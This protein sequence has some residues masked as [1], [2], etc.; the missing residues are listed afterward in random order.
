MARKTLKSAAAILAAASMSLAAVACSS[1]DANKAGDAATGAAATSTVD[2]TVVTTAAAAG[3]GQG[4]GEEVE[5]PT[6]DGK[7]EKVPAPIA[8][9]WKE[10]GAAEGWMGGLT[11]VQKKDGATLANFQHGSIASSEETGAHILRGKIRELWLQDGALDSKVGLPVENE[12]EL[13]GAG[14]DQN[15]K[16]GMIKWAPDTAGQWAPNIDAK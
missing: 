8:A 10:N 4:Q 14:W 12:K 7:T 16:K 13:S 3:E 15:F 1:E 5:I 11:D 2:T 9:L 6:V